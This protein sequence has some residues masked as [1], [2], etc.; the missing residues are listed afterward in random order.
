MDFFIDISRAYSTN[1]E[2]E[3][4]RVSDPDVKLSA[5]DGDLKKPVRVYREI[6]KPGDYHLVNVFSE[7]IG[8]EP[9]PL[10]FYYR[11]QRSILVSGIAAI[12]LTV[13]R[14]HLEESD[15]KT[16]KIDWGHIQ[17]VE[18]NSVFQKILGG[19]IDKKRTVVGAINA[20]TYADIAKYLAIPSVLDRIVD[21]Q[22]NQKH[23]RSELHSKIIEQEDYLDETASSMTKT[24]RLILRRIL[25]NILGV[26]GAEDL[27][28]KY[29]CTAV[30]GAPVKFSSWT[31]VQ[32]KVYTRLNE[33]LEKL[34]NDS[35]I[36]LG[37][38]RYYLDRLPEY[39][40]V[41]RLVR[42][43]SS[44]TEKVDTP[45]RSGPARVTSRVPGMGSDDDSRRN[46]IPGVGR[47]PSTLFGDDRYRDDRDDRRR[48][49]SVF[50]DDRDDSLFGDR[51][52]GGR[53]GGLFDRDS[54]RRSGG[55]PSV[56][57][58]NNTYGS[59]FL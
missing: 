27:K 30:P 6:L 49:G 11:F 55:V 48:G 16:D 50:R 56:G 25:M 22:T 7:S 42:K 23:V 43:D 39:T 13:L 45:A 47:T 41:A 12:I 28:E 17:H 2:G 19:K 3:I 24:N 32:Y 44:R 34:G 59:P 54:S 52:R 58:R 29:T 15:E 21:I 8:E 37:K 31:E 18:P 53:G 36:D 51:D 46:R 1:E 40:A 38:M 26:E 4:Y 33:I 9:L 57:G 14:T 5:G 35:D 20:S 10:K